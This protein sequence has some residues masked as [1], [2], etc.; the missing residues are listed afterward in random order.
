[1]ATS[2][3]FKQQCPSCEAMVPVRDP[4]L[5]GKKID[6]PKCKYRFVV[7]EPAPEEDE[8]LDD[9]PAKGKGG[10][11]TAVTDKKGKGKGSKRLRDDDVGPDENEL[12]QSKPKPTNPKVI[13]IGVGLGVVAVVALIG[14][15]ILLFGGSK[16]PSSGQ[17][18]ST[19]P[20]SKPSTATPAVQVAAAEPA[21]AAPVAD[22]PVDDITNLLPNETALLYKI[23]MDRLMDSSVKAAMLE[24]PGA[25]TE[26]AFQ[27]T[28][29]CPVANLKT[30]LTAVMPKEKAD[31]AAFF[32]I[33]K[34]DKPINRSQLSGILK[35]TPL[36]TI[37]GYESFTVVGDLDSLT[38]SF[39]RFATPS[40]EKF[41][42][43]FID[44]QTLVFAD[45][46]PMR[47]FLDERRQPKRLTLPPPP[48]PETGAPG[49]VPGTP[50]GTLPSAQLDTGPNGAIKPA[51][52]ARGNGPTRNADDG[53][54][55]GRATLF[56]GPPIAPKPGGILPRPALP[57]TNATAAPGAANADANGAVEAEP[58]AS[59]S[60]MTVDPSLKIAMDRLEQDKIPTV[61]Y[62]GVVVKQFRVL[63]SDVVN[64]AAF[65]RSQIDRYI[66]SQP[67]SQAGPRVMA[68][69]LHDFTEIRIAGMMVFQAEKP[70]SARLGK[71]NIDATAEIVSKLFKSAL[72]MDVA[73][74][75][76]PN[77]SPQPGMAPGARQLI[78]P[79][80]LNP[81]APAPVAAGAAAAPTGKDGSITTWYRDKTVAV[82]VDLNL[83]RDIYVPIRDVFRAE[84]VQ[85]KGQ[86]ELVANRL[87]AY[88]LVRALQAYVKEHGAFPRGAVQ[89][90]P[91]AERGIDWY[92]DQR[93]SWMVELLPYLSE[94]EFKDLLRDSTK[95]WIEGDNRITAQVVIP[96]FL[97]PADPQHARVRYPGKLGRYAVTRFVGMAGVGLDA[98]TYPA[99]NPAYAKKLGVFGYDRV[100]KVEDIHDDL[101][102]TIVLIEIP[103]GQITPW[104]A[105]GGSTVRGVTE[106]DDA[107]K[108][109]VCTEY[110]G[111]KGTFALMADWKVR[112]IP[113]DM[114]PATFRAMCTIA[115]GEPIDDLNEIAPLVTEDAMIELKAQLLASAAP[116]PGAKPDPSATTSGGTTPKSTAPAGWREIVDDVAGYAVTL[117][118]GNNVDLPVPPVPGI[119]GSKGS[120]VVT[121]DGTRFVVWYLKLGTPVQPN[122]A[123]RLFEQFRAKVLKDEKISSEKPIQLEGATGVEWYA[124]N[125]TLGRSI[126]RCYV[127]KDQVY[128]LVAGGPKAEPKDQETFFNSFR[129]L[130]K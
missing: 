40:S 70:E 130:K 110:K 2:S 108:Q 35:L 39:V 81:N 9:A 101:E 124:D 10:K 4:G 73:V 47:T 19:P 126:Q 20:P 96:Q 97:T 111:K 76:A 120:A 86:A 94:G 1:M 60:Y 52:P 77:T 25:F 18:S 118:D 49:A 12:E 122:E 89:R 121:R 84:M 93:L 51:V 55:R 114:K 127:A 26:S 3:S 27:K 32:S 66:P 103:A 74:N 45:A 57:E 63:P 44:D 128:F 72:E 48:P 17:S 78:R 106:G 104:M 28:F 54:A 90:P 105:G 64:D 46:A 87:R 117:P 102:S 8:D 92:P 31:E 65:D 82:T 88:E 5:V 67:D 69:A 113:E 119:T 29:G 125:P 61:F 34:F 7:E 30:V 109:F 79:G 129:L 91:N 16:G 83:K 13:Y 100:T 99:K 62:V 14:G 59:N 50:S 23:D 115:G 112:F 41:S 6:C 22:G 80:G 58:T 56:Q 43:H 107:L 95:S 37:N 98:A 21:P 68:F 42:L 11:S 71:A 36:P 15:G 123:N 85:L 33:L 38:A 53:L 116:A 75:K 24:W